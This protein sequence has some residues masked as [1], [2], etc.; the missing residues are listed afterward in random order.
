MI[1][2]V[3]SAAPDVDAFIGG[4]GL[5]LGALLL[6]LATWG[7]LQIVRKILGA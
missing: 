6:V 3:I 2:A 1:V 4:V 7:G 5:G